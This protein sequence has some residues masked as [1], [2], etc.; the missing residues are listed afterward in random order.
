MYM[1][2]ILSKFGLMTSFSYT[3]KKLT[4]QVFF[5]YESSACIEREVK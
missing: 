3:C 2:L 5:G 1:L 4:I